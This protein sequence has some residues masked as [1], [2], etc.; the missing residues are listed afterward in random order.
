MASR[1]RL[2]SL[3]LVALVAVLTSARVAAAEDYPGQFDWKGPESSYWWDGGVIPF[4]YIPIALNLGYRFLRPPRPRPLLF[5][6]LEGGRSYTGGQYPVVLLYVDAVVAGGAILFAGDDSRWHHTKGFVQGIAM[7]S[8]LTALAKGTFG[9]QRP[10][11]DLAIGA[12]NPHDSRRSFW[13]GHSSVTLATATYLGLYA[14]QHLFD[15]W[16]PGGTWPWWEIVSYTALAAGAAAIPY[17][18]YALNRHHASDVIIGSLV[19]ATVA[20][21]TYVLQEA[22]YRA[23]RDDLAEP[24]AGRTGLGMRSL[25]F[26]GAW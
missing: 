4:L 1:R 2:S 25:M 20:V 7:T 17:S 19:G 8:L 24:V 16:R 9:R 11:F 18:Q 10:M 6:T 12:D 26:R 3:G 5:S 14:R 22:S 21:F 13:S 15:R 23:A